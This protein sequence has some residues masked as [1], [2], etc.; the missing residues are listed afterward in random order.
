M[1]F[2]V[3]ELKSKLLVS[4]LVRHNTPLYAPL[5]NPFKEFRLQL[6]QPLHE[7]L[8]GLQ[9]VPFG[10]GLQPCALNPSPTMKTG[11]GPLKKVSVFV[12]PETLRKSL[13]P[14]RLHPKSLN[15]RPLNSKPQI[16][17]LNPKS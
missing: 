15:P 3:H 5:Y 13:K 4:P 17:A 10:C 16:P 7:V 6:T 11:V 1:N 12:G 14:K 9:V 8:W 2:G